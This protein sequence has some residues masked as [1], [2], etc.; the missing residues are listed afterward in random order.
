[1]A[2]RVIE[3]HCGIGGASAALGTG[4]EVIA[5]VDNHLDA[6]SVYPRFDNMSSKDSEEVISEGEK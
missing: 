5:A 6:V 2:L 3:W 1:M 4:V